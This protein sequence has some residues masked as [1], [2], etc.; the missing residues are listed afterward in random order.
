M[1]VDATIFGAF[2][3]RTGSPAGTY[4]FPIQTTAAMRMLT[5]PKL[6]GDFVFR[7]VCR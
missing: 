2:R 3:S 1:S 4:V 7:G 6:G 5:S